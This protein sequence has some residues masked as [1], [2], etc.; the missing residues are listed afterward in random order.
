MEWNE[1]PLHNY[2]SNEFKI[3][4]QNGLLDIPKNDE[5]RIQFTFDGTMMVFLF[6]KW[7]LL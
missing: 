1:I 7:I 2:Y 4:L 6:W 3:H 5:M